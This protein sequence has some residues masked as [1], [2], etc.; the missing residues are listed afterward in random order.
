MSHFLFH[1]THAWHIWRHN[2]TR[3]SHDYYGWISWR[4]AW[5]ATAHLRGIANNNKG[6]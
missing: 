5:E 6:E 4:T 1:L 3:A 2:F